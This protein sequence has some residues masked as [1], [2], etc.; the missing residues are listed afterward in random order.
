MK[1]SERQTVNSQ[2]FKKQQIFGLRQGQFYLD[3][4]KASFAFEIKYKKVLLFLS[5]DDSEAEDNAKDQ[6]EEITLKT[7]PTALTWRSYALNRFQVHSI[8]V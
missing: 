7:A 3:N 2:I 8:S 6:E 1:D 4:K 5:D